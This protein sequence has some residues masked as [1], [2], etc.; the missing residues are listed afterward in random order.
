MF[1]RRVDLLP[2][3]MTLL[4]FLVRHYAITGATA[5]VVCFE[6]ALVARTA[7]AYDE[8]Q[9]GWCA[10]VHVCACVYVY[11]RVYM[12]VRACMCVCACVCVYCMRVALSLALSS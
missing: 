1:A 10:C 9:V 12:C 3:G 5:A 11:V 6:N 7:G 2:S 4:E 8:A